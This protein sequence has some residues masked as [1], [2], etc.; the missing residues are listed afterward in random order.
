MTLLAH[1]KFS[2]TANDECGNS[3]GTWTFE[4]G[5]LE[6][7]A[8]G[9]VG[10]AADFRGGD[11]GVKAYIVLDNEALWDIPAG[12]KIS[13]AFWFN[14]SSLSPSGYSRIFWSK[15]NGN[16]TGMVQLNLYTDDTIRVIF[17]NATTTNPLYSDFA[18]TDDI[19][20]HL[21]VTY[22]S[23]NGAT[24][25]YINGTFHKENT[26]AVTMGNNAR[27]PVIGAQAD[28]K[29]STFWGL[30]D[31]FYYYNEIISDDTIKE[32]YNLGRVNLLVNNLPYGISSFKINV[33]DDW[34]TVTDIKMNIG[35]SW[36]TVI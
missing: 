2:S 32:L 24:R 17:R 29:I 5:G 22:D 13:F 21:V 11:G 30:I 18:V 31:D 35:N 19:W 25:M 3:N 4:S 16:A 33:N 36:K 6:R 15:Y 8:Q 27:A 20:Y 7:Y 26:Q 1:Y 23:S 10:K 14:Y 12:G 34:K 9:K 28:T